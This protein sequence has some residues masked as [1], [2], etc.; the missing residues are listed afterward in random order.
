M[1]LHQGLEEYKMKSWAFT[2]K[3]I[4]WPLLNVGKLENGT[5]IS[6]ATPQSSVYK[7]EFG[8]ET[9]VL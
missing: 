4:Y 6:R 8:V 7:C 3:R 2:A 9:I 1:L 5:N